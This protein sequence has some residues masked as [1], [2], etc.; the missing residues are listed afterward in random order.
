MLPEDRKIYLAPQK[1]YQE[2]GLGETLAPMLGKLTDGANLHGLHVLLKPNLLTAK[3]CR[4]ACTDTR[5]ILAVSRWFLDQG[6]RVSIGDSPAFGSAAGV[7]DAMGALQKLGALG[8]RVR[9]FRRRR[10]IS[11]AHG[12]TVGLAEAAL[13]CDLLVNLPKVKAHAQARVTLAV[14]NCFGCVSGFQK[15]LRHMIHG[16]RHHIFFELIASIPGVLPPAVHLVDGIVAMHIIGPVFGRPFPL[17]CVA[18][19][20]NP[21]ALDTALLRILR[22]PPSRSPLWLAERKLGISGTSLNGF[23]LDQTMLQ[24][25]QAD[26]FQVPDELMSVRFNPGRFLKGSIRRLFLRLT[27]R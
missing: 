13:D 6:S 9:N 3:N 4:L 25:L 16:G 21:F 19:S 8:V 24:A 18:G 23:E 27:G 5:F 10:S 26:G 2:P 17:G 11:L 15:P 22:L 20:R 7:L 14:K 12:V 1:D